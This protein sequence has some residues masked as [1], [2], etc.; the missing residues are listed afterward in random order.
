[1]QGI[2]F[3]R[4]KRTRE[5]FGPEADIGGR[6]ARHA[7]KRGLIVRPLDRMAVLSPPLTLGDAEIAFIEETLRAAIRAGMDDLAREGL[8]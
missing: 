3:V 6:I 8:L 1:M 2:E 5:V 4:D 7:Q